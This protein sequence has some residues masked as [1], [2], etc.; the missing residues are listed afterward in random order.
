MPLVMRRWLVFDWRSRLVLTM[1]PRT[2]ALPA[3]AGL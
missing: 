3:V 1:Y 2:K